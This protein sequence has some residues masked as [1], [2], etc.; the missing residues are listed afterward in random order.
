M[1]LLRFIHLFLP[2]DREMNRQ[3]QVPHETS[4]RQDP[5][6]LDTT[7]PFV[8]FPIQML[9][10]PLCLEQVW[11]ICARFSVG[12]AWHVS[13]NQ[14]SCG[15]A[16]IWACMLAM[17]GSNCHQHLGRKT[18]LT[19]ESIHH[20][21]LL[22]ELIDLCLYEIDADVWC[23]ILLRIHTCFLACASPTCCSCIHKIIHLFLF[24]DVI[25]FHFYLLTCSASR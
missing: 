11:W 18:Q 3:I 25:H 15:W 12:E 8:S 4:L 10:H 14:F 23:S 5:T 9:A 2:R 6:N 21:L 24:L 20:Q 19:I 1:Y 7:I 16:T 22:Y 13:I 17:A